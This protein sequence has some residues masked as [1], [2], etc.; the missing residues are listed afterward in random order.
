MENES[1]SNRINVQSSDSRNSAHTSAVPLV[2][3]GSGGDNH[4]EQL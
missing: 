2:V 3:V 1:G 4:C